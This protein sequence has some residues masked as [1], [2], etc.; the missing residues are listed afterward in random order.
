MIYIKDDLFGILMRQMDKRR[1]GHKWDWRPA[2]DGEIK[3]IEG[4]NL[5]SDGGNLYVWEIR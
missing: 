2:T 1:K 4:G 3:I 5:A